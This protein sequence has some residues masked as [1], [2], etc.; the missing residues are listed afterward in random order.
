MFSFIEN[1]KSKI[2]VNLCVLKCSWI[3]LKT[4][5]IKTSNNLWNLLLMIFDDS[6]EK[7][8]I[9]YDDDMCHDSICLWDIP[10]RRNSNHISHVK[11][12]CRVKF[13]EVSCATSKIQKPLLLPVRNSMCAIYFRFKKPARRENR[14]IKT[15]LFPF[16]V[17]S[18]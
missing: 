10:N 15:V 13:G 14:Q 2:I 8:T 9:R 17:S 1:W 6:G 18:F 3:R 7:K 4:L 5:L 16:D 11:P 12:I